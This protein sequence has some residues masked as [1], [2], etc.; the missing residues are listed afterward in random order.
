MSTAVSNF[1]DGST[2]L[3]PRDVGIEVAPFLL[4]DRK[5]LPSNYYDKS[6]NR[7][8][9]SFRI[10]AASISIPNS[11]E[12]R[13]AAIGFRITFDNGHDLNQNE[14]YKQAIFEVLESDLASENTCYLKWINSNNL[15]KYLP[16]SNL[17]FRERFHILFQTPEY[18]KGVLYLRKQSVLPD[19][20]KKLK[21]EFERKNW[22]AG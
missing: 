7:I 19:R 8:K 10:S 3:L 2:L 21:E 4:F 11:N 14:N 1:T 18:R 17:V 22:N 20:L 9:E 5:L 12:A 15:N 16:D 13:E 6:W